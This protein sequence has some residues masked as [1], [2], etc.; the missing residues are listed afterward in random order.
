MP[1]TNTNDQT[2]AT[3]RKLRS[4]VEDLRPRSWA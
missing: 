2:S 4:T 1:E 3:T